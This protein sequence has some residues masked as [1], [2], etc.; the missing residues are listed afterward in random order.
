MALDITRITRLPAPICTFVALVLA[1]VP[2]K[3]TAAPDTKP[4]EPQRFAIVEL[5]TSEGCS[6]C[7]P[8]DA[9]LASIHQK[10]QNT[11]AR[12]FTLA[13]H[14]DYWNS[15]GWTDRFSSTEY[16]RRQ[17][18]YA[19]AL[20]T[21]DI[22]TPQMIVNGK[23]QFVGSDSPRA[24]RE[25][26][27]A[28]ATP[29]VA[30]VNA[31][32]TPRTP[33]TPVTIELVTAHAPEHTRVITCIVEDQLSTVVKRG[34]NGGRTL[35]HECVVR[36]FTSHPADNQHPTSITLALPADL[37]ES[38]ATIITFIQD[39]ESMEVFGAARFPL[40]QKVVQTPKSDAAASSGSA[41]TSPASTS[42]A[43]KAL[44]TS[45]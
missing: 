28:L 13:F 22:Y 3:A 43:D 12:V 1:T 5:F 39:P 33:G 37:I 44:H 23:A 4:D 34:E 18:D 41:S 14:V 32:L 8:A 31:K 30:S 40:A 16:T 7:P 15:L 2:P 27:K 10:H 38:N 35:T 29:A 25:I 20:K 24:E 45:H 11:D 26:E 21:P 42:S 17:K 36:T 19:T 6:S 9:V